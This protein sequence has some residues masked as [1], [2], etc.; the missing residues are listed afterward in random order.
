MIKYI[1]NAIKATQEQHKQQLKLN[2]LIKNPKSKSIKVR[3]PKNYIGMLE[4]LAKYG[5][6]DANTLDGLLKRPILVRTAKYD[7]CDFCVVLEQETARFNDKQLTEQAL[8]HLIAELVKEP[9]IVPSEREQRIS[10]YHHRV[11]YSIKVAIE[12]K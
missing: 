2:T 10:P 7:I 11:R 4:V 8:Y 12:R 6:S 5:V 9:N 3:L 1:I